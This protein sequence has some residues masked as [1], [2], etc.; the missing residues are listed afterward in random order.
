M[1]LPPL[2]EFA[3]TATFAVILLTAT[4]L[5]PVATAQN[6]AEVTLEAQTSGGTT[7]EVAEVQL[8]DPGFVAIHDSTIQDGEVLASVVGA[9]SHL[10]AG[11][12]EDVRVHLSEPMTEDDQLVA[13]PHQD[14]DGDGVYAFVASGGQADGPFT[15]NGDPVTDAAE[16]TA[17]ATV[18]ASDQPTDGSSVIVDRVEMAEGGFVAVHDDRLIDGQAVASVIG[19]SAYLPA[20]VHENVRVNLTRTLAQDETIITMPHRDSDD[21]E[22]YDFVTSEASED[23]PYRDQDDEA[24]IDDAQARASEEAQATFEGQS[25]GG[26]TVRVAEVFLPEGGFVTMHDSTLADGE[27][28]QSVRG[29]SACLEPGVH[30]DVTVLLE[31][32]LS[33]DDTLFAMPHRDTDNDCTYDFVTSD[34]SDDGPYTDDEGAVT[35]DAEIT[36][37]AAVHYAHQTSDGR[38]I[39]VDHVDLYEGGFVAVHDPSLLRGEVLGSVVGHS[40]YLEAGSHEDIEIRLGSP[41]TTSQT[42]IPMPHRDTDGDESY[43]FLD[44]EGGDDGPFVNADGDAVVDTGFTTVRS[45]VT[46]ED[47][48]AEDSLT[49]ASV[50]MHDGGFVTIHDGS[51]LDGEVLGSV[52]GVSEK[53]APGTHEDVEVSL[54]DAPEGEATMIAMPHRDTN[55]NG[56]Y[57]FVDSEGGDD[58]PYVTDGGAVV[59][60]ATVAF[61]ASDDGGDGGPDTGDTDAG[62]ETGNGTEEAPSLGVGLVLALVAGLAALARPGRD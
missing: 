58:G 12:H 3:S 56:A 41:I 16:V 23:P 19:H 14:S 26:Q 6:A 51:L 17:S 15:S 20:G 62:G 31:E 33:E 61:P 9:S 49:V 27:T 21:D 46:I 11:T 38:T 47:Q 24:V 43:D 32:P 42:L 50:T 29:T 2:R 34:G 22:S 44:S 8:P 5:A 57:D 59:H 35:D 60:D 7:V 45:Q 48:D 36:V 53:L 4:M 18:K 25:S 54:D 13:M 52:V 37:S 10:E 39:V 40:S 30:R 55:G 28:F 1:P